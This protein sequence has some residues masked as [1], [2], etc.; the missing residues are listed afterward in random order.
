MKTRV[1][2][3]DPDEPATTKANRHA[4]PAEPTRPT[5]FAGRM[6]RWSARHRKIAIFGWLGFVVLA[7]LIGKAAGTNELKRND[8]IPGESGRAAR[9]IDREFAPRASETVL[10]QSKT[11]T[12]NDPQF[13]AAVGDVVRSI[14]AFTVVGKIDSPYARGNGA[15]ISQDRQSALVNFEFKSSQED[16]MKISKPVEDAV[17]AVQ[18]GHPELTIAEFGDG[19]SEREVEGQFG[20][21]LAKAGLLSLPVTLIILLVTF[22]ALVAAGIPLLLALTSV[23]AT[24][25]L[26]ALPSQLLPADAQVK[27]VI[28]LI[29]LAVGVDYSLFYLK[30]EREERAAGRSESAALEAAAATSGRSVLISGLTVMIA[31]AGM[32]FAGDPSFSSFALGAIMVVAIAMLGSLT[33]LPALLSKLGDRVDRGRVPLL[34]RLKRDDDESRF[35]SWILNR[36]LGRPGLSAVIA[37]G[38]LVVIALPALGMKTVQ[39]TPDALPQNLKAV[40]TYNRINK[41]FPNELHT[42]TVIVKAAHVKAPPIQTAVAELRK[43]A[44]ATIVTHGAVETEVNSRGTA[45]KI[46]VPLAGNGSNAL[47][48]S[49]VTS[50]RKKIV[51]ATLGTLNGVEYGVT[52]GTAIDMDSRSA[53]TRSA[54]LVFAFVLIFAFALL[55]ASFRSL[56]IA[57][58][59][60]VLNLLSVAAAYGILVLVF[61]H[62]WGKGLLGFDYTGG[63]TSFLPIFLFVIL[64]GLSMDYHVF[65][66][67]RIREARDGGTPTHEAVAYG[68]KTTAG[69]VTSAAI[70]MVCVFAVF[71]TGSIIVLQQLG[72]GLAAAVLIDATIVRAVLLPASM[73]LLGDLNWYLPKWLEWLPHLDSVDTA[74]KPKPPWH[75]PHSGPPPNGARSV[76]SVRQADL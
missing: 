23:I 71:A 24:M 3:D 2:Q 21:D 5:N 48:E 18:K 6:G 56:V 28:L 46:T 35:W 30:R 63:I 70:V 54:P 1:I 67:S 26:I 19:S 51:P 73:M 12:A 10:V 59:A 55:L 62:G 69:V 74:D 45:E 8:T 7:V 76:R 65:I 61:Q 66:I 37:G 52:G 13:R 47:S 22:G 57:A 58:K 44:A 32:F 50:L 11:L 43:R 9:L 25:F 36:V 41:V 14:G 75:H 49:G 31:M 39:I 53:M 16:A 29:G 72:V 27:E 34:H 15:Q 40:Q 17:S 33:V 38:V 60:V 4:A 20:K 68:I 64:F 42:A